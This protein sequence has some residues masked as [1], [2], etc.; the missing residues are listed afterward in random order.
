MK[1]P[2]MKSKEFD[3][4]L[5]RKRIIKIQKK[6]KKGEILILFA[7]SHKI[8]NRDVE[9]KFRQNS[10]FYYLTGIK[11]EDSI[12]ILTSDSA[13]MF[14]LPKDKEKEIW[15]GIRL[16]KDKIKSMLGLDYT[17]DLSEWEK[18]KSALLIDHHTL[19]YF[20]GENPERDRE[21]LQEI[22]TLSERAREG[23][24]GPHR[25]EHPHFLHEE[26]LT[27][28]KEE[29]Q[30]L[31]NAS[32]ITKFGHMRIMRESKPGMYEYE[33]E[34]LLEQEYLK[35]GSIGGGYGHI[36]ASGQNAC[37]L[38]YVNNDDLLIEGDL[39]LVDS[40]AEWNYYTADVTRVFPVGKKFS[41]AQKTIYE[42]VLYAQ[43]N[44]I[45]QS[46]AGVP[47]NDVHDKTVRFLADCLREM[48]F[49]KGNL[50]E[51]IE[52]Q[53]FKKFYMHRTGH[54]LG[55]DVHDVG[56]YFL[57]GKSRPLK[58][59]QVVTVEPGLYFDPNDES[60]PKE[61]R[62]IGIRIEDDILINGK[63]PINLTESIPKEIVE[64]EALKA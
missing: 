7:A 5:F 59:G 34:A 43:K 12:F 22:K 11:E 18:Q 23:K 54:Y 38:H 16:G 52:K 63:E 50:E 58:D 6:L 4:E 2:T 25:I 15:T 56:R 36:V 57:D 19:Y 10:D 29:I 62:G 49:L 53:S 51:I 24:F 14:C 3:S 55:M 33:L 13:G 44:A 1:Q 30:I 21:I 61:F 26:R 40:G 42:V 28:S 60:I 35:Y 39:V 37:I 20:F 31:K 45:R 64:I 27:K 17:Y 48:G 41:E 46:I 8:R 9:Y 47:F 32:E